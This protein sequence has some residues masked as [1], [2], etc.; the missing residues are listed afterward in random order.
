MVAVGFSPRNE[1]TKEHRVASAPP[2][3]AA[4]LFSSVADATHVLLPAHRG[5]KPT[6][7]VMASL[8]EAGGAWPPGGNKLSCAPGL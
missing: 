4:A 6:A 1:R 2:E 5:L 7:T 8:R 3:S